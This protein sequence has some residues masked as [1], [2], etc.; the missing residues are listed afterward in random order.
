MKQTIVPMKS[1]AKLV[2]RTSADL[3]IEGSDQAQLVAT[4]DDSYSFRMKDENGTIYLYADSDTKLVVPTTASLVLERVS[5]DASLLNFKGKAEVQ[6]IGG[7]FHFQGLS[8]ITIETV[9]GD[10]IFKE[11]TGPVEIKRV[12]GDLDGFQVT[13]IRAYGVGGDI[14]LSAV[15]GKAQVTAGGDAHLQLTA[16][17]IVETKV[18]AG[19]DIYVGVTETANANLVMN[20][21]GEEITVHACGQQLDIE[22]ED[23]TLPL[24]QGGAEIV[25]N[26]GGEVRVREGKEAMGEFSFVIEDINSSWHDFGREIEEKIRRSMKGVNHQLRHAS[27]E[28]STAMRKAAEQMDQ[29]SRNYQSGRDNRVVGFGFDANESAAPAKEKS[30]ASDEER[31]MILKMLQEKKI[32]VEEAEKLLQALEG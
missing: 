25:L 9:G 21:H 11:M 18:T 16:D 7:D 22:A 30:G 4:V 14:E 20:S 19:G 23:Y 24:G 15:K 27:W 1:D 28:A 2:V 29:F 13:D 5:G 8:G 31:M 3:F 12:G 32:T 10:C 17:P 26:A 6:K